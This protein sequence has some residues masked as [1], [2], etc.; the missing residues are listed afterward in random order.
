MI[1]KNKLP[2]III[3]VA[4]AVGLVVYTLINIKLYNKTSEV[5]QRYVYLGITGFCCILIAVLGSFKFELEKK[6]YKAVSIIVYILSL[7]NAMNISILFSDGFLSTPYIYLV[8]IAF[9]TIFAAIGLLISGSMRASALTALG[10][11]YA[12]NFIS[13]LIYSFR[14]TSLTPTDIYGFK[15]AMNVAGSYHFKL[16][17]QIITSTIMAIAMMMLAFKFPIKFSFRRNKLILRLISVVAALASVF[18]ISAVDLANY[19]V[20]VFD[21]YF[22]NLKYGSA[23]SFYANTAKMGLQKSDTYDP[24]SLNAILDSY[25]QDTEIPEDKPN[26]IVVMDESFSDLTVVGDFTTNEGYIDYFNSLS[27]NT[28][29]GEMLVSVFGGNT[30]NTEFEFLTGMNTGLLRANAIPYAQMIFNP[31]PYSM[32][33]HMKAMGYKTTAFHPYYANGWNRTNIY[34]YMGF[35]EFISYE[36]MFDYVEHAERLRSYVSDKGDFDTILTY[37]RGKEDKS[38]RDFIFNVTMQNHG[39]FEYKNFN[40]SVNITDME[41]SYPQTEQY[42]TCVKHTDDALAYFLNELEN[43]DEPTVVVMFGD[44]QPNVEREFYEE[45]YGASLD[46]LDNEE[47]TKRYKVPFIIWANYDIE[48]VQGIELS[49]CFLSGKVMEVAGLPKSRMQMYLD[50]IQSEVKQLHPTGYFDRDG[51]WHK[52]L[53]FEKHDEYY[54]FEYAIIKNEPLHYDFFEEEPEEPDE[55]ETN[56]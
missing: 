34:N 10:V 42:L 18:A 29:R 1:K 6:T 49:P 35:D 23:F 16:K 38:Q 28:V 21:Q 13:F 2:K 37:L 55:Q 31:I 43:Y 53:N 32:A 4:L 44:H 52:K 56:E 25:E 19:D 26:I 17:Y 9:Y 48:E 8:N 22:A 14:G 11:S 33:S 40:C 41:G 20:S 50:D 30:C 45:L 39:G 46:D 12:F 5:W 15:T 36:T 27:K 47:L 3:S 24:D 51:I 7:M 54:D